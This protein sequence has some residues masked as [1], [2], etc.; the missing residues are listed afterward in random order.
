MGLN[1]E[2][3]LRGG[4][5]S[6]VNP[7]VLHD[8]QWLKSGDVG[9]PQIWRSLLYGGPTLSQTWIFQPWEGGHP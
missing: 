2:S 4:F 3:S 8:A 9:E 6:V 1:C 7:P 5:F